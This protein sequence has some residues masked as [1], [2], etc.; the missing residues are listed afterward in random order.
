MK[1][2]YLI[3]LL[4]AGLLGISETAYALTGKTEAGRQI[5]IRSVYDAEREYVGTIT[6]ALVDRTGSILF[7][8]LCLDTKGA[9]EKREIVVPLSALS[10]DLQENVVTL[11][12]SKEDLA[13]APEFNPSDLANPDFVD[14]IFGFYSRIEEKRG[15]GSAAGLAAVLLKSAPN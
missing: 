4:I 13:C 1:K 6:N 10:L 7:I 2:E 5:G 11:N 9:L 15:Q 12:I 14:K 3:I 8:V